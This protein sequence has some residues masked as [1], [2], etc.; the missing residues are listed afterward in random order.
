MN[1]QDYS[2]AAG[3]AA[4]GARLRR[5]SENLD[6]DSVR[7]YAALGISFEQRWFGV[8]NQLVIK[9][10]ATVG[11]LATTLRIT[12][13]SVSQTR[14]SLEKAGMVTSE[15]DPVDARKKKIM[16]TAAGKKLVAE[17]QPIW[18]AFDQAALELNAEAGDVVASLNKLDD[19]LDRQSIFDRIMNCVGKQ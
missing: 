15:F 12:H 1:Q 7:V 16:L 13:V 18:A 6:A 8:L 9:G 2:R 5:L 4:I 10:S 19:A 3:G 11:E 17:L 14:Q